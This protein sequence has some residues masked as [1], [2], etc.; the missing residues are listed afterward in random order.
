MQPADE[1]K[2]EE[3]LRKLMKEYPLDKPNPGFTERFMARLE[4][5]V[6]RNPASRYSPLISI[7]S[8]LLIAVICIT[9]I[10]VSTTLEIR[11]TLF[12]IRILD[13][14]SIEWEAW[15]RLTERISTSVMLY[16][17]IVLIVGMGIQVFYL[18]RWHSRQIYST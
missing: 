2:K 8:G 12:S 11:Q 17:M 18:K 9:V 7:R 5:E 14:I 10:I 15:N 6:V 13:L 1:Y 4:K 3:Q 16:A